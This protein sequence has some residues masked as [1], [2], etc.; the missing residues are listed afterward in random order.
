MTKK[1]LNLLE[2]E[3]SRDFTLT[4]ETISGS[5]TLFYA[6]INGIPVIQADGTKKRTTSGKIPE[7]QIRIKVRVVGIGSA[8]FKLGID[9]PGTANDQSLTLILKNGY[10]ETEITL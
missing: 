1:K 7:S 10:Y 4:L 6:S 8:T 3:K 5:I 2:H 9:L